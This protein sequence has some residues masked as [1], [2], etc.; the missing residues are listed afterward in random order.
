MAIDL[1]FI[2]VLVVDDEVAITKL[3]RMLLADFEVTRVTVAKSGTEAKTFLEFRA[4]EVDIVICDW[5]MPDLSG[6]ELL[7]WV[8]ET[9]SSMPFIFL[10]SRSDLE[11]VQMA[12][13]HGVSDY[14]LKPFKAGQLRQKLVLQAQSLLTA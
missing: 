8:R 6:L 1:S 11:S 9:G 7:K 14:L 2:R 10:T 5:N 3:V 12:R 4:E 13:D